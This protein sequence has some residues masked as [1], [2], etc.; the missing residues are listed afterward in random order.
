MRSPLLVTL[1]L[2][3]LLAACGSSG[4][5][6]GSSE[7]IAVAAGDTT[8]DVA[9]TSLSAGKVTFDVKNE[10][11]DVTEVYVYAK[12]DDGDFDKVVGEVENI[13][14]STSRDFPVTLA[15][16]EYE[17]ACKPGQ[18]GDGIRTKLTVSGDAGEAEED[19]KY[20]REVEVQA[21]EYAFA[22][23]DGF[24][25]KVG[26]KI[27]FKLEN[28]G[29]MQHE[30]E[31][32]GPDGKDVGEVGPTDAGADGE[33]VIE[34]KAAGTYTYLCGIADHAS[35]GMKGTFTVTA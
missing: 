11:K 12:G 32:L 34:F 28:K 30:F 3:A 29:T 16:G 27:E 6:G 35:R 8:C 19:G 4:D 13:A 14:P 17:V 15:G 31:I 23:M 5:S 25:A 21:K 2:I 18:K 9:K 26:E 1:P 24:T 22:G 33:V 20:D 10:G 7:Q